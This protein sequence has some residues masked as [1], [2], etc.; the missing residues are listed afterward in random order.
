MG[1]L[2]AYDRTFAVFVCAPPAMASLTF[3][4]AQGD[5]RYNILKT[6]FELLLMFIQR[7]DLYP[8]SK[9]ELS[10]L[11][12]EL[13][14]ERKFHLL[15]V[16]TPLSPP[17]RSYPLVIQCVCVIFAPTL[18]GIPT[19]F[20]SSVNLCIAQ[21]RARARSDR[22]LWA[23]VSKVFRERDVWAYNRAVHIWMEGKDGGKK[24]SGL[25][26]SEI[27]DQMN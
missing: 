21:L 8:I 20:A 11:H 18:S 6:P 14:L 12:G 25:D 4:I 1:G 3:E 23:K 9:C 26:S 16:Q 19:F 7:R 15:C 2:G 17:H 22:R 27:K 5:V 10:S 24:K 13:T